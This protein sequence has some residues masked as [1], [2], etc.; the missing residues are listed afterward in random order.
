MLKTSQ[1]MPTQNPPSIF[2]IAGPNGAGKSTAAPILLLERFQVRTYV[3]ADTIAAGLSAFEPEAA[4]FEA[5]RIMLNRIR[6][7]REQRRSFAFETTLATRGY[8]R[9][10]RDCQAE[11][12]KVLV[13]F[14]SL[15][16]SQ[17]AINRVADRVRLGGHHV[18][19]ATVERRYE[20]GL[21]KLLHVVSANCRLL[22]LP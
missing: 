19:A 22:V 9:W 13:L 21:K 11:G 6:E 20:R 3:N 14:L 1:A 17:Q 16:D 4:A 2:V 12:F 7:L 18:P 15:P 10:L 5:G 8:A